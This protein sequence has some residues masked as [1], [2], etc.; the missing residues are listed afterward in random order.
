M[1]PDGRTEPRCGSRERP[2]VYGGPTARRDAPDHFNYWRR[3]IEAYGSGFAH[4]AYAEAGVR[5]PRLLSVDARED[6]CVELWLEDVAGPSGFDLPLERLGR[7]GYELGVG[8][9]R[10]AGRVPSSVELPWLSRRWLAQY[11]THGPHADVAVAESDWD[12]PMLRVW[13]ER[14][15]RSLRRLWESRASV[16]EAA[17]AFP[18]TLCHLDLWPANVIVDGDGASVLIDW[19]FVGEGAIGEDLANLIVDSVTDGLIDMAVLPELADALT[20]G[21][22]NGLADGG[23]G[24]SPDEV[25][26]AIAACGAAKYAWLGAAVVAGA[27]GGSETAELER[28]APLIGMLAQWAD[29]VQP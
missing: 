6:G 15:R 24:G 11:S 14:T 20:D 9:A 16:L 18:R 25:R 26:A 19:A 13:P 21:Y 2:R 22:L 5:A 12:D 10:W 29:G 27:A 28:L 8:Q 3:E 4:S 17:Q 23:W 7:F 1:R